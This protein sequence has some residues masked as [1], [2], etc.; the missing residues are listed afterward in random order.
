MKNKE[1]MKK[2]RIQILLLEEINLIFEELK[3]YK[4]IFATYP[5]GLLVG[6]MSNNIIGLYDI[7]KDFDFEKSLLNKREVYE[8]VREY[9]SLLKEQSKLFKKVQT[10]SNF[11][12]NSTDE[13]SKTIQKNL[14]VDIK[15][16]VVGFVTNSN[17]SV[18]ESNEQL[19]SDDIM[20]GFDGPIFNE[21][22][23]EHY[24]EMTSIVGKFV[25]NN[26]E[27]TSDLDIE[28]QNTSKVL[29]KVI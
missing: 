24:N 13:I 19:Q 4:A 27:F 16:K 10:F 20:F 2:N 17:K 1:I 21:N 5:N 3:Y 23:A 18:D 22:D 14:L 6:K 25:S 9:N 12:D 28:N 15:E 29:K 7:A 11:L 8:T 26:L